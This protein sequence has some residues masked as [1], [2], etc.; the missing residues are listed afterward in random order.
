MR[1]TDGEGGGQGTSQQKASSPGSA[2]CLALG[3]LPPDSDSFFGLHSGGARGWG[4]MDGEFGDSRCY[5]HIQDGETARS[6][7]VQYPGINHH[8]KDVNLCN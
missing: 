6:S 4:G 7:P 5:C 1:G 3:N 2:S 8:G